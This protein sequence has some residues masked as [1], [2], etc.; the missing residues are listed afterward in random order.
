MFFDRDD[1][2]FQL[3]DVLYFKY[4][5]LSV[6]KTRARPFCALSLRINGDADIEK[7]N[8]N[9]KLSKHDLTF[10]PDNLEYTRRALD[11]E[12]IVFHFNIMNFAAHDIEVLHEFKYNELLPKFET[13]LREWRSHEPGGRY[14][15]ASIL[16]EIFGSIRAEVGVNYGKL[17]EPVHAAIE[18]IRDNFTDPC[19]S[20]ENVAEKIHRTSASIR[21]LFKSELGISPK[22]YIDDLRFEY[23]QSLLNTGYYTVSE[24]AEKIG[25][26]DSK[27]FSTAYK[28]RFGYSPSE[29]GK[30]R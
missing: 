17:S 7:N 6:V 19:M 14:R 13:A 4:D 23:A 22:K 8:G 21:G 11:D 9:I 29:Q 10:F 16:Y 28:R 24:V 2:Q 12:M 20:V 25:Y 26:A 1:L 5:G 27:G 30:V 18:Y 3:M 15:A